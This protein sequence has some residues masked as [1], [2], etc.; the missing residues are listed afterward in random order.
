MQ[1]KI[2]IDS[3]VVEDDISVKAEP[4]PQ[5]E[6][7]DRDEETSFDLLSYAEILKATIKQFPQKLLFSVKETADTLCVSVEFIRKKITEQKITTV[8][9]GDRK[10]ISINELARL[11]HKGV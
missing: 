2:F 3:A 5:D 7:K 4:V 6:M 10:L 1:R 8:S 11:I 9:F